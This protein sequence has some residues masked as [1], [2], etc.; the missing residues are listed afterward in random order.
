MPVAR[1]SIRAINTADATTR[2]VLVI[3]SDRWNARTNS[4]GVLPIRSEVES[5]EGSFSV[6]L[7][8]GLFAVAARIE[9]VVAPPHPQSRLGQVLAVATAAQL[10]ECEDAL[11][12]YLQIPLLLGSAT[13]FPPV[14]GQPTYPLWGEIYYAEPPIDDERKRYV[15]VSPNTWNAASGLV[16]VVRTTSKTK[17]DSEL[18]PPLQRGA[19]FACC[20][21]LTTILHGAI[22][23]G[24]RAK[25]PDPMTTTRLDMNS[26][27]HGFLAA[28]G[29]EGAVLRAGLRF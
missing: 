27:A 6:E 14:L 12:H 24:T 18:F 8:N 20:G 19:A 11:L 21:E 10:E 23:Y 9:A 28:H 1:G 29:S 3:T 15:V 7:Q 26:I 5:F 16:S 17:W 4:V 22:R 13:R 2:A 25:R